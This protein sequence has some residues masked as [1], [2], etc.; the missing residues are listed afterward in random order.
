MPHIYSTLCTTIHHVID[1]LDPLFPLA[2]NNV[3]LASR[4]LPRDFRAATIADISTH[5]H[6]NSTILV[7]ARSHG[8]LDQPQVFLSCFMIPALC[9]GRWY[10]RPASGSRAKTRASVQ[11]VR[12]LEV[13]NH[14]NNHQR[15][16][17][18]PSTIL[19]VHCNSL[20]HSKLA[21]VCFDDKHEIDEQAAHDSYPRNGHTTARS[22]AHLQ[23]QQRYRTSHFNSATR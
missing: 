22:L 15:R 10:R 4:N 9:Y 18:H 21:V 17:C 14:A 1:S 13:L 5:G 2:E 19:I 11:S 20:A 12:L 23:R 3:C 16:G 8:L 6:A 7:C